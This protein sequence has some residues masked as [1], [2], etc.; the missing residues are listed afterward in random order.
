MAIFDQP[1]AGTADLDPEKGHGAP[2]TT[3]TQTKNKNSDT[4]NASD[5]DNDNTNSHPTQS[6]GFRGI[7]NKALKV[8]SVEIRGVMPVPLH[9]RTSRR[10]SSYFTL[11]TTLNINLLP[12][13]FGMLGPAFGLG[14]RDSVL[15]IVFFCLLTA[16]FPAYLGTLGPK[17]GLRQMVQARFSY[18]RYLVS[19]P[20]LFN[21]ATLVG[22]IVITAVIGGQCLSATTAGTLSPNVGIVIIGL[23][24]MCISFCGYRVVHQYERYAWIP[25]L[26][27]I[28]I[29]TGCGGSQ[30]YQQTP[31]EPATAG[32][33]LSFGMIVASYMIP[34]AAIAS[35]FTTYLS[36]DFPR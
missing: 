7:L 22:F 15:V 25:A 8:S 2:N 11:W 32:A 13:T 17:T 33:V 16:S 5:D 9:E 28:I 35:D 6:S 30:L 19:I 18:G 14:L 12:I 36:P 23:L 24:A 1:A 27:A 31:A 3:K 34:Y 20:V 26:I 29:T 21:L 10:Y 4:N